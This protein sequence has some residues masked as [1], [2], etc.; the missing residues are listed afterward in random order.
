M[1][2]C[3]D[4]NWEIL[5]EYDGSDVYRIVISTLNEDLPDIEILYGKGI[6]SMRNFNGAYRENNDYFCFKMSFE[7]TPIMI[8]RLFNANLS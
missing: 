5:K 7:D 4:Y 6:F 8:E 3:G 1:I 2:Q